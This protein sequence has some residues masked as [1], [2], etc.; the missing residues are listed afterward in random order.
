MT[1][2]WAGSNGAFLGH[3]RDET[4]EVPVYDE[5]GL[6]TGAVASTPAQASKVIQTFVRGGELD[7]LGE[8]WE[9][10]NC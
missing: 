2:E 1:V 6:F 7:T 10:S 8:W 3:A 4:V 9:L 5:P